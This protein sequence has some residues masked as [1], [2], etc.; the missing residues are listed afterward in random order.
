MISDQFQA[1]IQNNK[2]PVVYN[3]KFRVSFFWDVTL[4]H[5]VIGFQR[6]EGTPSSRVEVSFVFGVSFEHFDSCK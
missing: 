3:F 2:R 1:F 4:P 6:F 5:W